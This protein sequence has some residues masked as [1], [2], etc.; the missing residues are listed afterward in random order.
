MVTVMRWS[1]YEVAASKALCCVLSTLRAMNGKQ[2]SF[3]HFLNEKITLVITILMCELVNH[4]V[5]VPE[6]SSATPH[7]QY[8]A[9]ARKQVASISWYQSHSIMANWSSLYLVISKKSIQMYKLYYPS[10]MYPGS[11]CQPFQHNAKVT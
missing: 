8:I 6:P 3:Y 5:S 2:S 7:T 4:A 1:Y 11:F 9:V 10:H